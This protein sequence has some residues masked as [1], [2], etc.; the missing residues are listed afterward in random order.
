MIER[1]SASEVIQ[2][3]LEGLEILPIASR[4][5]S[6]FC[7]W[8]NYWPLSKQKSRDKRKRLSYTGFVYPQ[9][10]LNWREK[11]SSCVQ[12]YGFVINDIKYASALGHMLL[13][14]VF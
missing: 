11:K 8:F 1:N 4:I 2:L 3:T 10:K 5:E 6:C 13:V 12:F 7:L 9:K 14:C